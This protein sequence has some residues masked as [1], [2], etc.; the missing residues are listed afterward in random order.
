MAYLRCS[1]SKGMQVL[2]NW[3]YYALTYKTI[4]CIPLI[5]VGMNMLFETVFDIVS[6]IISFYSDVCLVLKEELKKIT[7]NRFKI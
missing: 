5:R 3:I 1:A 4:V 6:S 7:L 2:M